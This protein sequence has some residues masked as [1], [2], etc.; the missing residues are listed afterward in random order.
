M[1]TPAHPAP[2]H[3]ALPRRLI[4]L[5]SYGDV[6]VGNLFL[7]RHTTASTCIEPGR[8]FR[9]RDRSPTS[10]TLGVRASCGCVAWL[11][12]R[13]ARSPSGLHHR[14]HLPSG[15]PV[16]SQRTRRE[17]ALSHGRWPI[18]RERQQR[19]LDC[20]SRFRAYARGSRPGVRGNHEKQLAI[21]FR[22]EHERRV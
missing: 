14:E 19:E 11:F 22:L 7:G 21:A 17:P 15:P 2:F 8:R 18:A 4:K 13:I 12:A 20:Q 6:I 9:G 16:R 10:P 5:Y 1:G 3:I